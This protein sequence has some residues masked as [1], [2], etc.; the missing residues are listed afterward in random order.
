MRF[1]LPIALIYFI[2]TLSLSAYAQE[3]DDPDVKQRYSRAQKAYQNGRY[4][5]VI[6]LLKPLIIPTVRINNKEELLNTHRLLAISYIFEKNDASAETSFAAI[7][8]ENPSFEFNP[9]VD[10]PAAVNALKA[11]KTRNAAMLKKIEKAQAK[12]KEKEERD[13]KRRAEELEKLRK[14]ARLNRKIIE[15]NIIHRPYWINF[16]PFGAG[17]FQNGHRKKGWLLLT[18]QATAGVLSLS[19]ALTY[20]YK[21]PETSN[22]SDSERDTAQLISNAQIISGIL[23]WG[24]VTYGIIDALYYYPKDSNNTQN[25]L[26]KRTQLRFSPYA[27]D[28][29]IGLG[30][31]LRF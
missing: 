22:H 29:D 4:K 23:F 20:R 9:L 12:A 8:A 21:Y 28:K 27:S 15:R 25:R 11:Y 31:H 19:L 3:L 6:Q 13:K 30:I 2:A 24:L 14:E 1:K 16:I 18:T 26:T 10:P 17:Q 7:L 5:K